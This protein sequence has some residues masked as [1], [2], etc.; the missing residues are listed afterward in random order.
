MM[1]IISELQK[2]GIVMIPLLLGSILTLA[3]V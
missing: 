1:D 2:G 3:I